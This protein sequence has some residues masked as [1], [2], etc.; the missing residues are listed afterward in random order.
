MLAVNQTLCD[1]ILAILAVNQTLCD[2]ILAMLAV[3]QTL[4]DDI[5]AML[6]V[7]Q[8]LCDDTL[9][10]LAVNQT[11]CDDIL[12]TLAVNQTFWSQFRNMA[13]IF[14]INLPTTDFWHE[15]PCIH[16]H[17]SAWSFLVASSI[18][19]KMACRKLSKPSDLC[20]G[21][22]VWWRH[23]METFSALVAF[24]AGNSPVTGLVYS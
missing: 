21:L 18:S 15:V 13:N 9:A 16:D 6:A 2:D 20:L 19:F 10:M 23:Q 7:N 17:A 14:Q 11:L 22:S 8:T 24:C 5:L 1:D 3:N 12:A 4:C